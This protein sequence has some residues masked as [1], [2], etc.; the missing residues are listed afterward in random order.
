VARAAQLSPCHF[1]RV[2]RALTGETLNQ[3]V[4]RL[5]LEKALGLL[6]HHGRQTLTEV[7]LAS[8][9]SSSSDF[10]RCFK[11]RFGVPPSAF[12]LAQHRASQREQLEA[13]VAGPQ[14]GHGLLRL[15]P[16]ENPDRFEVTLRTLPARTVAYLRVA[17]SFRERA[18][19]EA[20][21]RLVA[22]AEQ[23]GVGHRQWLGYMWDDPDVVALADCRYDVAVEVDDV[24]PGGEIGRFDF[25]AMQVAQV[26]VRGGIDLE[27]RALDWLFGTWLPGSGHVPADLPCFEAWTGRPFAHGPQHFELD[28]W[29]PVER[30]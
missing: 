15:P 22:W 28:L 6:A 16:G 3:F 12:N 11:Q 7:A 20:A 4:K 29:L 30:A 1:H 27:M 2:F 21:R 23:R 9:F 26:Q 13:T 14:Q 25:P 8:G 10:S 5:R 24:Q 19:P 17:D 18:V